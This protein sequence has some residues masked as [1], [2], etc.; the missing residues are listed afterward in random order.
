M[1]GQAA[2]INGA[3]LWLLGGWDPGNK[4]DGGQIKDDVWS[5]DLGRKAWARRQHKARRLAT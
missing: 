5:F 4:G 2:V 1:L 3:S